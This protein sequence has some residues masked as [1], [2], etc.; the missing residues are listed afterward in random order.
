MPPASNAPPPPM[1]RITR[2]EW[3]GNPFVLL[4]L[5]GTIVL[6]PLGI[7]YFMTNLLKIEEAVKDGS[8]VSEFLV[9][10]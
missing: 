5:C 8:A 4:L 7:I 2:W 10:R 6:L 1:D 3:F 9:K